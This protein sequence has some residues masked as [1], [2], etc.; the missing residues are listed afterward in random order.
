LLETEPQ[1]S[2][3]KRN[4]DYKRF[5]KSVN[6]TKSGEIADNEANDL[7]NVFGFRTDYEII[8]NKEMKK[9]IQAH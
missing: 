1:K 9:N 7:H 2:N 3:K 8:T 6:C 4:S 5:I